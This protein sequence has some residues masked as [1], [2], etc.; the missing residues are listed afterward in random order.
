MNTIRKFLPPVALLSAILVPLMGDRPVH[1]QEEQGCFMVDRSGQFVNL[2]YICPTPPP[3]VTST[4]NPGEPIQLGT[5]DIQVT[6]RWATTDDLDLAVTDPSGRSIDFFN[7]FGSA[8]GQL[9]VDA[10]ADCLGDVSQTPIENIFWPPAS[11][12]SGDYTISVNLFRRC[13]NSSESVP[14]EITLLVQGE[15]ETLT[16]SVNEATPTVSFPFTSP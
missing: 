15:T 2:S 12:P 4:G 10:N 13:T 16:G 9:D 5:G 11:A 1:S 14:F 8:G 6:L 7:R 3:F